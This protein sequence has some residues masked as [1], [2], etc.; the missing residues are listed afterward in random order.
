[1]K[2]R[3]LDS[4]QRK[5]EARPHD[6]DVS[7]QN[8]GDTSPKELKEF[9]DQ[10]S[11]YRR[12]RG[13][14]SSSG[15]ECG[16]ALDSVLRRNLTRRLDSIVLV[17]ENN[18]SISRQYQ[19]RESVITRTPT[20]LATTSTPSSSPIPPPIP[21]K[22]YQ[23]LVPPTPILPESRTRSCSLSGSCSDV[24][25]IQGEVFTD[26]EV[27][28]QPV[29]PIVANLPPLAPVTVPEINLTVAMEEAEDQIHNKTD[30]LMELMANF[31][32]VDINRETM[33]KYSEKLDKIED[34]VVE[35]NSDI[36]KLLRIYRNKG[37]DAAAA[38]D[39]DSKTSRLRADVRKHRDRIVAKVLELKDSNNAVSDSLEAEKLDLFKRQVAAQEAMSTSN[40]NQTMRDADLKRSDSLVEA[41]AKAVKIIAYVEEL[42]KVV[43]ETKDWKNASDVTVKKAVRNIEK[44]KEKMEKIIETKE[45]Y[46]VL[47]EK[48]QFND[49]D[50]DVHNDQ[51]EREVM[52]LKAD[53]DAAINYIENEDNK[54]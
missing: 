52:D 1:M 48:N 17:E 19:A 25:S 8:P 16:E 9:L 11:A 37:M 12:I 28:D 33:Q 21:P 23:N 26:A 51:V 22:R 27:D 14:A 46:D 34:L 10:A 49:E 45:E 29:P 50:D 15:Q 18:S 13:D 7:K 54:G 24:S 32:V 31:D 35:I 36:R 3:T 4:R 2:R 5:E 43:N 44:W 40:A 41:R 38:Q 53:M 39:W 47:V 30:K 6:L 42:D 20:R